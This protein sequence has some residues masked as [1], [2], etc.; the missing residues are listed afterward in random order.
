MPVKVV[1][2]VAGLHVPVIAGELFELEGNI[3]ALAPSQMGA[4]EVNK[5]IILLLTSIAI[6]ALA[7]HW[8]GS[9]VK[10]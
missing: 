8:L 4:T 3:G 7:A 6:L 5:G 9:A 1:F 2:I 10:L